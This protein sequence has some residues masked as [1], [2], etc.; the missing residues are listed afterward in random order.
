[1]ESDWSLIS[2]DGRDD[3]VLVTVQLRNPSPVDRRVR[4]DNRLDGPVL[5]PRRAG[6]PEPGW[7]DEGFVGVVPADGR[8][9]LGYACPA[10]GTRPPV[11]VTDEGRAA[12]AAA[13]AT[14]D[15]AVRGLEESRPPVDALPAASP[16]AGATEPTDEDEVA[17]D[18]AA[19]GPDETTLATDDGAAPQAV[20][21]WLTAVE[22]RVERGERLTDASVETATTALDE[23]GGEV[24]ELDTRVA[25]DVAALRTVAERAATLADR[26]AAVDVPVEALRRLA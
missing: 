9:A 23:G 25:D 2:L 13:T 1:M 24:A 18:G 8:R 5:P 17:T 3:V 11:A 26:A 21:T 12:E 15:A 10:P 22:R 7:D 19:G 16:S 6:V 14:A 4:I 20:K